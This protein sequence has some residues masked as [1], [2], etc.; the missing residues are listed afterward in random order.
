MSRVRLQFRTPH[1]FQGCEFA[2][3]DVVAEVE[4]REPL[5]AER[6]ANGLRANI[7]EVVAVKD[8]ETSAPVATIAA[9]VL[10]DDESTEDAKSV[11]GSALAQSPARRG[12]R[13]Q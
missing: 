6:V 4:L 2:P 7:I 8:A 5:T 11:A 10:A 13:R 3:G 9:R 1:R 12:R